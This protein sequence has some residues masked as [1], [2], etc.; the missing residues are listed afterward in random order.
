MNN[1]C[2]NIVRLD[3]T[4]K[5]LRYY[6][7]NYDT[8]CQTRRDQDM[9]QWRQYEAEQRDI[10]EI[11]D[12]IARFGHGTS[13]RVLPFCSHDTLW[14]LGLKRMTLLPVSL[15]L[16]VLQRYCQDGPSGASSR[17]A[18]AEEAGGWTNAETRRGSRVGLEF[19]RCR[20]ASGAGVVH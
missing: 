5:K 7:G 3:Q 15:L 16:Y 10:A 18:V 6:G 1:V 9:V 2:T 12:F 8:Y 17:K 4:Y 11:K 19:P 20:A 14:S 13:L